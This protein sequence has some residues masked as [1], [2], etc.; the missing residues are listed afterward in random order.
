MRKAIKR[1][2][3]IFSI[4]A[5]IGISILISEKWE[6][7]AKRL[8]IENWYNRPEKLK[9]STIEYGKDILDTFNK[10]FDVSNDNLDKQKTELL[11]SIRIKDTEIKTTQ[12]VCEMFNISSDFASHYDSYINYII[13]L[14]GTEDD[15]IYW[16]FE[17]VLT[18]MRVAVVDEIITEEEAWLIIFYII[19][20]KIL[21]TNLWLYNH[22]LSLVKDN[23]DLK[24]FYIESDITLI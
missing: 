16:D 23:D 8:K 13:S 4:V 18:A 5:T 11:V 7:L 20:D 21:V 24:I 15:D 6:I 10:W 1:W 3:T 19:D 12:Q 9:T 22:T 2:L 14:K 17:K